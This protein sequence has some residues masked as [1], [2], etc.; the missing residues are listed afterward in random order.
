MVFFI[1]K[2]L[3][4]LFFLQL[5]LLMSAGFTLWRTGVSSYKY[6]DDD[7]NT[8]PYFC[9]DDIPWARWCFNDVELLPGS[10]YYFIFEEL[11]LLFLCIYIFRKAWKEK[12]FVFAHGVFTG[13]QFV[14]LID[15]LLSY[16]KTW[17]NLG[18]FY[19]ELFGEEISVGPYPMSWNILKVVI[20]TLTIINEA[21]LLIEKRWINS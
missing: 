9:N 6:P 19:L 8:Y 5:T 18:P 7:P 20:F 13:L 21:F 11:I 10:Y 3:R 12:N 1:L 16:Q 2:K 14:D 4:G 17:M 15:Y